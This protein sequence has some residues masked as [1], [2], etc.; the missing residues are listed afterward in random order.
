MISTAGLGIA[1]TEELEFKQMEDDK[2]I[3]KTFVPKVLHR[4]SL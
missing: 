4:F 1:S 2:A 3:A